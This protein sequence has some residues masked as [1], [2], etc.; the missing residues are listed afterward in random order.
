MQSHMACYL[1]GTI[2]HSIPER[3]LS[4]GE[5]ELQIKDIVL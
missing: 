5:W 3:D 1:I 4:M 2:A